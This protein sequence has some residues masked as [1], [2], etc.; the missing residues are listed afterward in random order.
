MRHNAVRS[1][2]GTVAD[3][4]MLDDTCTILDGRI[5]ERANSLRTAIMQD[6]PQI[7]LYELNGRA[8]N[9]AERGIQTERMSEV[10]IDRTTQEW[11]S[12]LAWKQQPVTRN[13]LQA[14]L[15]SQGEVLNRVTIG[16]EGKN[17][18]LIKIHDLVRIES[19][20]DQ[21]LER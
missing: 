11:Q 14:H 1:F 16:R 12:Y 10:G 18:E 7:E 8:E 3:D 15:A 2:N 9:V 21:A 13:L 4:E 19:A 5:A 20:K 6:Q 17:R